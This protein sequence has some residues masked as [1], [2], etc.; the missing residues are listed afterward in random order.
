[1][2]SRYVYILLLC[3][4][5]YLQTRA[6]IT[7][8]EPFSFNPKTL[9]ISLLTCSPG[10]EVWSLF[11]HTAIRFNGESENTYDGNIDI[12]IN[13]GMFSF[14]QPNFIPRFILGKTDYQMGIIPMELFIKEYAYE[15]RAVTEQILNLSEKDKESIVEALIV[16]NLPENITYRYNFFYNNCTSKARELITA[17][18]KGKI[19][20]N[21]KVEDVS[22]RE[23]T[24][25]YNS[26]NKWAQLGDDLLLG[27]KA[28]CSTNRQEQQFLP[29]NLMYDFASATYNGKPLVS[30]TNQLLTIIPHK[31]KGTGYCLTDSFPP[32]PMGCVIIFTIIAFI[33][34]LIEVKKVVAFRL[35]DALLMLVTGLMG[36][37]FTIMIFS[38]HPCVSINGLLLIF[39]PLSLFFLYPTI[40]KDKTL[41]KNIWWRLWAGMI[42]LGLLVGFV[43]YYPTPVVIVA[44]FLLLNCGVHLLLEHEIKL[45]TVR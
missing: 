28:D 18:L 33:I 19:T 11:G 10:K 45:K 30:K 22:F 26:V 4:F 32:S 43:Q 44:L 3:M 24:H 12:V 2:R 20:Y 38:E 15:G 40:R 21:R 35:W 8:I 6:S 39:N 17:S 23:L 36:V 31:S 42:I 41:K 14:N 16:N 34:N 5:A 7:K 13:Y 25:R 27:M 1:M 37:V 29:N 9:Q